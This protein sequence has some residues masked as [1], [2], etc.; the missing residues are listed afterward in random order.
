MVQS[1]LCIFVTLWVSDDEVEARNKAKAA[2]QTSNIDIA[3]GKRKRQR[4]SLHFAY[5]NA[6]VCCTLLLCCF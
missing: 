6:A 3:C 1:D 2:E 4:F 5:S